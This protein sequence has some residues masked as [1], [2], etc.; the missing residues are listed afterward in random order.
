[1]TKK[2]QFLFLSIFCI[3]I[4]ASAQEAA[5]VGTA[6]L[7]NSYCL[8]I[9][10]DLPIQEYYEVDITAF[11]FSSAVEAK[12]VFGTKCNNLITYT[13]DFE[14]NIVVAHLHLDRTSAPHDRE[15]W[16]AYLISTCELY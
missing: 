6:E 8:S 11:G 15:W 4:S 3:S 1:M 14:A 13:V 9:D 16:S 7:S 12:K 2:I 10:E 5:E